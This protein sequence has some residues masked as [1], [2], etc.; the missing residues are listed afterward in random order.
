MFDLESMML[1]NV[2]VGVICGFILVFNNTSDF[3]IF[4]LQAV[5]ILSII[6]ALI[7]TILEFKSGNSNGVLDFIR[8]FLALFLIT[9]FQM[10]IGTVIG[11][12]IGSFLSGRYVWMVR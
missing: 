11:L 9:L 10:I 5:I 12:A 6:L 1:I 4:F 7:S 2:I 8:S 3:W